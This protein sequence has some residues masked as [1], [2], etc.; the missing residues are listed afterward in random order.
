MSCHF[1]SV[2]RSEPHDFT[3]SN[4]VFGAFGTGIYGFFEFESSLDENVDESGF[5][6]SAKV[7]GLRL[8][9][10]VNIVLLPEARN[11]P[12]PT[13]LGLALSLACLAS[14][15]EFGL[16]AP[17][18]EFAGDAGVGVLLSSDFF[19]SLSVRSV[20]A[21]EETLLF[22]EGAS[23]AGNF[24]EREDT[25]SNVSVVAFDDAGCTA[26]E[27]DSTT[28]DSGGFEGFDAR[29]VDDVADEAADGGSMILIGT[30]R[31]LIAD[32]ESNVAC[33]EEIGT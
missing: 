10:G 28:G 14:L 11:M 17:L 24:K 2:E 3:K 33:N 26:R 30:R 20:F 9:R 19:W 4:N 21:V 15:N 7:V 31:R 5:G 13:R 18:V 16:D 8:S 23:V 6:G 27:D 1:S 29:T 22:P 25:G 12:P 32:E